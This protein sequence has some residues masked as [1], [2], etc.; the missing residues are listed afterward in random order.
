MTR[1]KICGIKEIEHAVAAAKNGADF[2]GMVFAISKRRITPEKAKLIAERV[3]DLPRRP[4]LLGVFANA[5]AA[6][7]NQIAEYCH[8][9]RVQ[10]SGEEPWQY[11]REIKLPVIKVMHVSARKTGLKIRKDIATG[12]KLC[13]EKDFIYLLDSRSA[14]SYGGTGKTFDWQIA[15]EI[16]ARHQVIVAGGL[17]PGNVS[18]LIKEVSPWGVDVS[19]GVETKGRKDTA[20]IIAFINAV[21]AAG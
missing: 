15:R 9:D 14:G 20:K 4:A 19:S 11:C 16:A 10:L 2:I 8:L 3:R 18:Q 13:P 1:I 6:E 5:P 7:V 12:L 17:N 21:R